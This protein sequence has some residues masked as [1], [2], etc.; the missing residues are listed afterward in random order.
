MKADELSK[1]ATMP[2]HKILPH[3]RASP[4]QGAEGH[5]VEERPAG[6]AASGTDRRRD[7]QVLVVPQSSLAP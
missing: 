7:P 4:A 1:P 2:I 6:A 3:R 5:P